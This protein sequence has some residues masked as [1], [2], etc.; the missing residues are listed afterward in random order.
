MTAAVRPPGPRRGF[1]QSR[2]LSHQ[3]PGRVPPRGPVAEGC[4]VGFTG[5]RAQG[6]TE[7]DPGGLWQ[8]VQGLQGSRLR[9]QG[10]GLETQVQGSGLSVRC[11][12]LMAQG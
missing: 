1:H 5:L 2:S 10:A 7:T 11:S 4:S 12:G 9:V 3:W 6:V 8:R